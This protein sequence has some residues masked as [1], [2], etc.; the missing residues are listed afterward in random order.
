MAERFTYRDKNG[1]RASINRNRSATVEIE[2]QEL[3]VEN[4]V[5][6]N[7]EADGVTEWESVRNDG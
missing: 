6:A 7:V 3:E 2:E 1:L 5:T 4:D